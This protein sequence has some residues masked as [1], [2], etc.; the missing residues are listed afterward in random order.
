ME[1]YNKFYTYE[2]EK[3]MR[4]NSIKEQIMENNKRVKK[5]M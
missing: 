4:V 1:N 3:N 5:M 2:S